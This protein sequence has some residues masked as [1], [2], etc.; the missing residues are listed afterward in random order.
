MLAFHRVCPEAFAE[1]QRDVLLPWLEVDP[2][3]RF[4]SKRFVDE[5]GDLKTISEWLFSEAQAA[6]VNAEAKGD[7]QSLKKW[8]AILE[9]FGALAKWHL[10][11]NLGYGLSTT[12][13][14][15]SILSHWKRDERLR[16][17]HGLFVWLIE[18][19]RPTPKRGKKPTPP[20]Y[21]LYSPVKAY[22]KAAESYAK[23]LQEWHERSRPGVFTKLLVD[24]KPVRKRNPL[25]YEWAA[26]YQCLELSPSEIND[27]YPNAASSDADTLISIKRTLEQCL[28]SP[29]EGKAGAKNNMTL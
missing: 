11:Y 10:K 24:K 17:D 27:R 14:M 22:L 8:I 3:L 28:I 19:Y 1:L 15:M 6:L 2:E 21:K 18:E 20:E 12:G 5:V 29:R 7:I 4:L 9:G 25:H 26:L 13:F 16:R 23:E